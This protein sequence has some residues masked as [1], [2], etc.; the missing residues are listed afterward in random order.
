MPASRILAAAAIVAGLAIPAA[1]DAAQREAPS[2]RAPARTGVSPTKAASPVKAAVAV[3]R[4]Y[5][6]VV[7]CSGR[8]KLVARSPLTPG[9]HRTADAWVTFDSSLGANDL[10]APPATYA[11]CTLSL[12]RWRWPTAASMTEDWDLV[13]ATV[14]HEM[15]HLLGHAHDPRRGN[16]M[17][18]VFTDYS[19]VPS[20]CRKAR[21]GRAR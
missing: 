17:V 5:W 2:S 8:V 10:A 14:T 6:G 9:V 4:R 12:A 15:G 20:M 21:P 13:C 18:P 19:S 1:A 16:I 11:N 3:A 7:P